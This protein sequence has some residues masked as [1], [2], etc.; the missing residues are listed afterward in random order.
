MIVAWRALAAA[1]ATAAL[2][3][4]AQLPPPGP[5]TDLRD[6]PPAPAAPPQ[7]EAG[8]AY[9]VV[10]DA[11]AELRKLLETYLDI[12]RFRGAASAEQLSTAELERLIAAAPAQARSLLETEGYFSPQVSVRRDDADASLVRVTVDPGPRAS[13]GEV[14]IEA[15]GDLQSAAT[16]G[17]KDAVATIESLRAGWLLPV[18]EPFRQTAWSGAKNALLA[19]LRAAGYATAAWSRTTAQVDTETNRVRIALVADSGPLFRTGE[20]HIEGL[21]YFDE[22]AVRRLAGFK[23]G[24]PATEQRLLDFQDRLLTAGL[25]ESAVV[26][27]TP[28][29]ARAEA[30]PIN[31]R[32]RELPRHTLTTGVG[33]SANTGPRVLLEH[34]GRKLF[35]LYATVT[36]KFEIGRDRNAWSGE[37]T[38]HPLPDMYRNIAAGELERLESTGEVR[39]TWNARVGRRLEGLRIERLYYGEVIGS[40]L[41]NAAGRQRGLAI[42]ANYQWNWRNVDSIILPTRGV[43]LVVQGGGGWAHNDVFDDGPFGRTWGR[44]TGYLPIGDVWHGEARLELGQV[45]ARDNVGVPDPLLFRA[46]GDGSV[47]GYDYRSLGPVVDGVVTSGRVVMTTGVEVARPIFAKLPTLWGAAFI[48]AGQAAD[49]FRSLDPVIGYGVGVRYRSPVGPLRVDIAYGQE[50]RSWRLHLGIGIAL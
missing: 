22:R 28:D 2:A 49:N 23:P 10:V 16:A 4:C 45:F 14:T 25:F 9:R 30:V 17:D 32:V 29:P 47:R 24:A 40:E 38:S 3:G 41:V 39:T 50:V 37:I 46:G 34:T 33:I 44:V 1:V 42:W 21:Q 18:G 8:A 12:E 31:V 48:D 7:P 27:F 26:E 5:S 13:I 11:P 19:R 15:Q 35:G 43:A 36:N 20:L 6:V